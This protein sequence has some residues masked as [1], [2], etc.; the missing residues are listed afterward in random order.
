[1]KALFAFGVG[2]VAASGLHLL[3]VASVATLIA[4]VLI[5]AFGAYQ[6]YL[7]KTIVDIREHAEERA[8]PK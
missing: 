5:M 4:G 6:M 2:E 3:G 8:D 1:M 7:F